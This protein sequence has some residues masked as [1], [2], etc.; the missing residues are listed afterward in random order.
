MKKTGVNNLVDVSLG[1]LGMLRLES[2]CVNKRSENK[3]LKA[4]GVGE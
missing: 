1:G 3:L 4:P 2:I